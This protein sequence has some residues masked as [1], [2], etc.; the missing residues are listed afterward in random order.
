M[1]QIDAMAQMPMARDRLEIIASSLARPSC[2]TGRRHDSPGVGCGIACCRRAPRRCSRHTV[3]CLAGSRA[4]GPAP[5][6]WQARGNSIIGR[7]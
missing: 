2:T 7:N 1:T 3:P 6:R 5:G 4:A